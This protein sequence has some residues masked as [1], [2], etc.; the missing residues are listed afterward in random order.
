MTLRSPAPRRA[1]IEQRIAVQAADLGRRAARG[2]PPTR[3]RRRH[4]GQRRA[5]QICG[6]SSRLPYRGPGARSRL[7]YLA[8]ARSG[9]LLRQLPRRRGCLPPDPP[10]PTDQTHQTRPT[11][12]ARA[13]TGSRS[14]G[15][16]GHPRRAVTPGSRP[17]GPV[18]QATK[19]WSRVASTCRP[20]HPT[21]LTRLGKPGRTSSRAGPRQ[22]RHTALRRLLAACRRHMIAA[23]MRV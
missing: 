6:A 15:P 18:E 22:V 4:A 9:N 21:R 14:R 13:R 2:T 7:P 10:D 17:R 20:T 5:R 12:P 16:G 3:A 23:I 11:R 8:T 1:V 19:T